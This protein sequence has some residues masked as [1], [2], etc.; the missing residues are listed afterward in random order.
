MTR[1]PGATNLSKM[2]IEKIIELNSQ[3]ATIDGI[4]KITDRSPQTVKKVIDEY[5]H[6]TEST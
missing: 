1:K 4:A 5:T 3:R 6:P 2:E